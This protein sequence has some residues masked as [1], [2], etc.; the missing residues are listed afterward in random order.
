MNLQSD[1]KITFEE[2]LEK[3]AA[4]KEKYDSTEDLRK[5]F[6]NHF[7]FSLIQFKIFK[8]LRFYFEVNGL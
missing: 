7:T 3:M 6:P 1:S 8:G 2:F 5:V 4:R